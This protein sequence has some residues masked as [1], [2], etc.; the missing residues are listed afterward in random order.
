MLRSFSRKA[1]GV[2][3]AVIGSV[4]WRESKVARGTII[5]QSGERFSANV[6][7]G[8][9]ESAYY[10]LFGP[11][12]GFAQLPEGEGLELD[13]GDAL[14]VS[15]DSEADEGVDC[16]AMILEYNPA[17]E[18]INT[19]RDVAGEPLFY[20]RRPGVARIVVAIRCHGTGVA[21]IRDASVRLHRQYSDRVVSDRF[22]SAKGAEVIVSRIGRR[23]RPFVLPP[24]AERHIVF[25]DVPAGDWQIEVAHEDRY[26][27]HNRRSLIGR[28]ALSDEAPSPELV[29]RMGMSE[30][31]R[32][33]AYAYLGGGAKG[34]VVTQFLSFSLARPQRAVALELAM[35]VERHVNINSVT[36]R[37]PPVPKPKD[38]SRTELLEAGL[39]PWLAGRED[40]LDAQFLLYA[41]IDLN[42]VDGSSIWLSSMASVLCGM[43][44]G[45]LVAKADPA[46]EIILGNV[47]QRENLVVLSPSDL[48][49]S[50]KLSVPEACQV[51][52]WLDNALPNVRDV[53]VRG[54]SAA[55]ELAST[56]QFRRRSRIYLTDFYTVGE[57]GLTISAEQQRLATLAVTHAGTVL[58]QTPEIAERLH[59]LTGVDFAASPMPPVIPDDRFPAQLPALGDRPIRI[60]YAGKINP[61]WG[62]SELLE[63]T[64]QLRITGTDVELDVVANKISPN[65][66]PGFV[67][68]IHKAFGELGVRHHADF[69]RAQSMA[70][71]AEMDFVWCWRPEEL[72]DH[73]LELSTKLVEM[74]A[75]GARCICYPSP[76]N[77]ALLGDDYPFFVRWVADLR[78]VLQSEARVDEAVSERIRQ[79]HGLQQVRQRLADEVFG[80]AAVASP[81]KICFAGHDMKFVDSYVSD[82][83]VRGHEVRHDYCGWGNVADDAR[84]RDYA[85]WA[86]VVFCEWGLG[87]A[88]WHSRNLP[89]DKRLIVRCH[90]QEVNERARDFGHQIA[91]DRVEKIIFVSAGVRDRA[92]ELFGWPIE[93]TVV[94]P[95]F[96]LDDEYAFHPREMGEVIRL[97]MVGIVPQRKR[98]DRAV[99]LMIELVGRGHRAEL[100]IKGPRP[101][102]LDFMRGA[103]R[104]PE[105]EYYQDVYARVKAMPELAGALH[106][107]D[108]G[109]NV[110]SWYRGIDHI[111]SCSDFESFH[112]ALADGVLS[113][114]HP[115]V[116]P[117]DEAASIYTPDWIVADVQ[118]AADRVLAFRSLS[119]DDRTT[120]LLANRALVRER[121]GR[122]AVFAQLDGVL[123]LD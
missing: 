97:G 88:V 6:T 80:H 66:Q 76:I 122:E 57:N 111:V 64:R 113:G 53:V 8:H 115:L 119:P 75:N 48:G 59:A 44:R 86:D 16:A 78:R 2:G 52:R 51:L 41:D 120:Q 24:M 94:I 12:G 60:G 28:V 22:G 72:E 23:S 73:T 83:K 5:Q 42:V 85:E 63:W 77:R 17:G 96:V 55:A 107:E 49:V 99:D 33:H 25:P 65:G 11:A 50:G 61:R 70:L 39:K 82:L 98:F 102:T 118:Q 105:L 43:G 68:D 108:W 54:L 29:S 10:T 89:D 87:N 110:S 3:R 37:R 46:T 67:Q 38:K 112:Y 90:L 81:R 45:I 91:I 34:D 13:L 9:D 84:S 32:G 21:R 92:I 19:I 31:P 117:W 30:C 36:L 106:F 58:T 40:L 121:Y 15:L 20:Y 7:L 62:V 18:R 4:G 71:M 69:D 100:F 79:R 14:E 123:R 35:P 56:R 101:E 1:L 26:L 103:S 114:S 116:W 93:K 109:N 95:N 47:Q 27:Q 74:V 104:A